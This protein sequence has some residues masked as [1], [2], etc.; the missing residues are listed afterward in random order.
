MRP[1]WR[2]TQVVSVEHRWHEEP[3]EFPV[4]HSV[5]EWQ[6]L[7]TRHEIADGISGYT[8]AFNLPIGNLG[9]MTLLEYDAPAKATLRAAPGKAASRIHR[10]KPPLP[11]RVLWGGRFARLMD[12]DQPGKGILLVRV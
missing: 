1:A 3:A 10:Q 7:M 12:G 2:P 4:E 5:H 11:C 6:G 9:R 8:R